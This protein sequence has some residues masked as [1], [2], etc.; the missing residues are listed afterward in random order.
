MSGNLNLKSR[1]IINV[2][3]A[4]HM[5]AH[6]ADINFVNTTINN[7]ND[8]N[9]LMITTY[10]GYVNERLNLSVGSADLYNTFSYIM[11]KSGQFWDEVNITGLDSLIKIFLSSIKK[12]MKWNYIWIAQNMYEHRAGEYTVVFELYF[13]SASIDHSSVDI[14]AR[15]SIKTIFW[16]SINNL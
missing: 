11:N 6:M 13:P 14:S 9:T 4:R 8:N 16:V 7:N 2:K 3:Q 12:S 15:S 5:K 1:S 10:Q